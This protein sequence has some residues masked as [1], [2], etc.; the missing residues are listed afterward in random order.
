MMWKEYTDATPFPFGK[1]KG[2]PI[3]NVPAKYLLW[4]RDNIKNLA[5]GITNYI[6]ANMQILQKEIASH[7]KS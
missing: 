4:C 3:A 6:N 2:K 7:S 5:P 1:Y